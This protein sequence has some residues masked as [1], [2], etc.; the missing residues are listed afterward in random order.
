MRKN[1]RL[2]YLLLVISIATAGLASPGVYADCRALIKMDKS[3][4]SLSAGDTVEFE[5]FNDCSK[6][7]QI[8]FQIVHGEGSL[9]SPIYSKMLNADS[10]GR[11]KVRYTFPAKFTS[12]NYQFYALPSPPDVTEDLPGSISNVD[13]S[14][15]RGLLVG[16]IALG[17]LIVI[18]SG[19]VVVKRMSNST[20]S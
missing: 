20:K 6:G 8:Q 11:A 7:R 13:V 19:W 17:I 9:R 10:A 4:E 2:L 1:T 16:V 5:I 18:A 12:D 14:G 3:P 15:N